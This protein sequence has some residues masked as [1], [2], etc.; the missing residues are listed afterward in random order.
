MKKILSALFMAALLSACT[1]KNTPSLSGKSFALSS[2]TNYTLSFDAKENKFFGKALNNY[3]GTYKI[4]DG[5]LTLTLAGMTM[6]AGPVPEMEKEQKYFAD[7]A[8]VKTYSLKDK[9]LELKG[10][11]VSMTY[12]EQ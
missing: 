11:G 9:I 4:K 2:D 12:K 10:D 1:S 7:L 8:K 3:F 5:H 6:M